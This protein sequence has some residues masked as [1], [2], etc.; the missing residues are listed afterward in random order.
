M[1][2]LTADAV[3]DGESRSKTTSLTLKTGARVQ[4]ILIQSVKV[5]DVK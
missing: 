2:A 4:L 1:D 5:G 3:T